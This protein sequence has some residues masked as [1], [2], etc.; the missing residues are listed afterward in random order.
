MKR[1]K[2]SNLFLCMQEYGF[3]LYLICNKHKEHSLKYH[4]FLKYRTEVGTNVQ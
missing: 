2:N 4:R 3:V 1:N